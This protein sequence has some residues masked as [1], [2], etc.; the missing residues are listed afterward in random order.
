[1]A[2][3]QL[4]TT[5][6]L[7]RSSHGEV[8]GFDVSECLEPTLSESLADLLVLEMRLEGRS[9]EPMIQARIIQKTLRDPKEGDDSKH[10]WEKRE[11][12]GLPGLDALLSKVAR[13]AVF[14]HLF[15]QLELEEIRERPR[16][17]SS[18]TRGPRW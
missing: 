7:T 3:R 2:L 10:R 6:L 11:L 16:S 9:K 4:N 17:Y 13:P 15:C 1:M 12:K 5:H 18:G 8:G 14:I